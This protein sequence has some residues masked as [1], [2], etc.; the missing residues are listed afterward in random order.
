MLVGAFARNDDERARIVYGV[1]GGVAALFA[2]K[3]GKLCDRRMRA[4]YAQ[5]QALAGIE[6]ARSAMQIDPSAMRTR[7]QMETIASS[8]FSNQSSS[9]FGTYSSSSGLSLLTGLNMSV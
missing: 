2:R 9:G 7:L 1:G 6:D 8:W 3:R 4:E 5:V